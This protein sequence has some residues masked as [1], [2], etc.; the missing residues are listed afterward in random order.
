MKFTIDI[1]EKYAR[2]YVDLTVGPIRDQIKAQL[3][4]PE[5]KAGDVVKI[6]KINRSPS[7]TSTYKVLAVHESQAWVLTNRG[8]AV[9]FECDELV[10]VS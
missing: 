9:T 5:P 6:K 10:V 3:P 1:D 7:T 8:I 4:K 2:S